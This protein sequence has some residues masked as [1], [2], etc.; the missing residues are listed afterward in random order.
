M[1]YWKTVEI[2]AED[3]AQAMKDNP[4][5][6]MDVLATFAEDVDVATFAEEGAATGHH[7]AA[8]PVLKHLGDAISEALNPS[9]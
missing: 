9:K 5:W 6:G 3:V 4:A 2:T 8:G 7:E 1:A